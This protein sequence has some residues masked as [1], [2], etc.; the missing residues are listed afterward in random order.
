MRWTGRV[1]NALSNAFG[2]FLLL[3]ALR[4]EEIFLLN[5]GFGPL[6]PL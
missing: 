4:A 5:G 6:L 1:E 2:G 3:V